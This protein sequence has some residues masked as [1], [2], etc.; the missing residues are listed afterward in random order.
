M[1]SVHE[2]FARTALL[3]VAV[4]SC[5]CGTWCVSVWLGV[6]RVLLF[7]AFVVLFARHA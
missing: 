3:T 7:A 2:F 1:K 5:C 6:L 4:F